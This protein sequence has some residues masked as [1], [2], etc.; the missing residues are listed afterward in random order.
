ML[1]N[2]IFL[3]IFTFLVAHPDG[4]VN[5]NTLTPRSPLPDAV[6]DAE[7]TTGG[8]PPCE[9]LGPYIDYPLY[10]SPNHTLEL[11]KKSY[12]RRGPGWRPGCCNRFRFICVYVQN[13]VQITPWK[14]GAGSLLWA[15][16]LDDGTRVDIV[17]YWQGTIQYTAPGGTVSFYAAHGNNYVCVKGGMQVRTIRG[18]QTLKNFR[19]IPNRNDIYNCA[20]NWSSKTGKRYMPD[21]DLIIFPNHVF[22]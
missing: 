6:L 3:I 12:E 17:W 2:K 22:P 15:F 5:G 4:I 9:Q 14:R 18:K 16:D 1:F 11:D 8:M 20:C 13:G 19:G 10:L 21:D 7:G